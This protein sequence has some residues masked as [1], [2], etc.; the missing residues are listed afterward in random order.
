MKGT[1]L[2]L[3]GRKFL[4]LT[5]LRYNGSS[6]HKKSL[7]ECLCDCGNSIIIDSGSLTSG[8]TKSC[9]CL[10]KERLSKAKL[11]HGDAISNELQ[12]PEYVAW[13]SMKRRCL[14]SN[15]KNYHHY[16]GRGIKVCE[17]W[18]ESFVNFLEDMGRKPSPDHSL[19][20]INNDGNYEPPNC[21]W[22]TRS[23]QQNN[24][25]NNKKVL[26]SL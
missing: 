4:R 16:G 22:A 17:R 26:L 10:H 7:W 3:I 13:S 21:R 12:T 18:K 24:K 19:D 20:R 14:N 5:V 15:D 9:G 8:H 25:R 11:I 2:N 6:K 23:E 1:S